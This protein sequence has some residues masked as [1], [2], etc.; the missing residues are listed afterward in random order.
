MS[1]TNK[2]ELPL[3]GALGFLRWLWRLNHA[4]EALSLRM[5]RGLG[6]TAQQRLL[7]RCVGKFPGITPGRLAALLCVDP[8]TVS[9]TTRRLLARDLIRR[10]PGTGDRRRVALGLAAKGRQLDHPTAGTVE[11]AVD[12]LLAV[13]PDQDIETTV[14]VLR[15]L[16]TYLDSERPRPPATTGP[17]RSRR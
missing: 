9:T 1:D 6:I 4:M 11:S 16:V 15:R 10:G 14:T 7:L 12:R 8:G 5:E 3:D 13:T 17:A 2:D